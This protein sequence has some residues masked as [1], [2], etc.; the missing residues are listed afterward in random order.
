MVERLIEQHLCTRVMELGGTTL[1]FTSPSRVGVP[2]RIVIWPGTPAV[3]HFV[4][5]KAPKKKPRASQLRE[6][7][8]LREAGCTV[9]VIDSKEAV[10]NYVR[11]R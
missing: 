3:I 2:D 11:N 4:E 1:K 10:D 7:A 8:R 5:V 9:L 6:H